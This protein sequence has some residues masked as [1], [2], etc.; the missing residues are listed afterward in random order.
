MVMKCK[1][2][3]K[4]I[5][6]PASA[7][8]PFI[9]NTLEMQAVSRSTNTDS[10]SAKLGTLKITG[11]ELA[12]YYTPLQTE[13][14]KLSGEPLADSQCHFLRVTN[15]QRSKCV[16]QGNREKLNGAKWC[17]SVRV[18]VSLKESSLSCPLRLCCHLQLWVRTKTQ[19]LLKGITGRV[20]SQRL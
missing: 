13:T 8:R 17:V 16:L 10:V 11:W 15:I 1:T 18:C 9:G 12:N 19:V 14:V 7:L 20:V 3:C 5:S 4:K 2:V 6:K